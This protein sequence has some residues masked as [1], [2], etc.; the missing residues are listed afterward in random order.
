MHHHAGRLSRIREGLCVREKVGQ[1][2]TQRSDP[3]PTF[4]ARGR[5]RQHMETQ[6]AERGGELRL[7]LLCLWSVKFV[8]GNKGRLLEQGRVVRL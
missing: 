2:V 7:A 8:Q 3:L 4:A 1:G 5:D 6:F